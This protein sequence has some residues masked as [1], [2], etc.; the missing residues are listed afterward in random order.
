VKVA[1]WTLVGVGL[2]IHVFQE[3]LLIGVLLNDNPTGPL[4]VIDRVPVT[5]IG[6]GAVIAL[7]GFLGCCGA[8][9]ESVCF[10]GF[11]SH[12]K[13]LIHGVKCRHFV[14][15]KCLMSGDMGSKIYRVI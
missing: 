5:L 11:V 3:T 13:P 14:G 7:I 1:G 2:W 8:C 12:I 15:M 4:V 10:L 9:T 6:C